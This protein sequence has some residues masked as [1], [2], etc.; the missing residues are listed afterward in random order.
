MLTVED[1]FLSDIGYRHTEIEV[2]SGFL[3]VSRHLIYLC[4]SA[5]VREK[6]ILVVAPGLLDKWLEEIPPYAGTMVA[7]SGE[8]TITGNIAK[9]GLAP[10]PYAF[11]R[12]SEVKF[13]NEHGMEARYAPSAS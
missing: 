12:V 2:V 4:P 1:V 8:A 9:S 11:Y 5:N 3:V 6:A 7:F 10:C 13:R